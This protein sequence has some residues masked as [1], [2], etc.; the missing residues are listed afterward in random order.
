MRQIGALAHES[1]A[2]RFSAYLFSQKIDNSIDAFFDPQEEKAS[3]TIWVHD[4]DQ[5]APASASF[6]RFQSN[7]SA[8][9]FNS[10][11]TEPM[12]AA[13]AQ[14]HRVEQVAV[15]P[16]T[17]KLTMFWIF[18]CTLVYFF[19]AMQEASMVKAGFPEHSLLMTPI[20]FKLF[21]DIPPALARLEPLIEERVSAVES[22]PSIEE[23]TLG[24]VEDSR[25]WQGIYHWVVAKITGEDLALGMGPIFYKIGQGEIWR[26]FSPCLLHGGLLH[27]AF[28][29]LWLWALGKEIDP[30]I[31]LFRSLLLTLSAGVVS[32]TVQY[33]MSGPFFLGYSGIITALAGFIWSRQKVAPWEGYPLKRSMLG[34]LAV[35]V[36]GMLALQIGSFIFLLFTHKDYFAAIANAAHISGAIWGLWLGRLS[37]FAA[38]GH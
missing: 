20:R 15:R 12:Q 18:L 31:G 13:P 21:Y 26:L 2:R 14:A 36:L 11:M 7:P 10:P 32:N 19:N 27:I 22:K 24:A 8:L 35:F 25:Y 16:S 17:S 28:N 9:E 34:F 30:R 38:R 33:L 37:F 5:I 1:L 23:K 4:E 6:E 29:M 3:Y